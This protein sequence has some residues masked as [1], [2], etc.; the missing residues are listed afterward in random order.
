MALVRLQR[1]DARDP[2]RPPARGARGRNRYEPPDARPQ[3]TT[4]TS[5][6]RPRRRA[7]RMPA[8]CSEMPTQNAASSM[9]RAQPQPMDEDVVGVGGERVRDARRVASRSRRRAPGRSRSA[10]AGGRPARRAACARAAGRRRRS[11]ARGRAARGLRAVVV[12]DERDHESGQSQ[13]PARGPV[14]RRARRAGRRRTPRAAA[15]HVAAGR[16]HR[17]ADAPGTARRA[18]SGRPAARR[19]RPARAATKV[20]ESAGNRETT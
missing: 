10:R 12:R 6:P 11:R 9:R 13:R 15:S 2:H 8:L 7:R 3:C 1:G 14:R 20:S 4:W 16:M 19:P 18:R 17:P 5:A